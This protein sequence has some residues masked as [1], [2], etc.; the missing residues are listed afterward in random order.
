M[1]NSLRVLLGATSLLILVIVVLSLKKQKLGISDGFF[2]LIMTVGIFICSLFPLIPMKLSVLLGFEKPSNFVFFA[3]LIVILIIIFK[4][5]M[6]IH[7]QKVTVKT[8]IQEVSLMKA[9][10][11][12]ESDI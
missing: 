1:T 2:W 5:N 8:L 12:K 7:K 10:E 11:S 6:T 3:G 9:R 4:Q